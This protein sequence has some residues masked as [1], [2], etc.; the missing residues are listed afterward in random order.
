MADI[1]ENMKEEEQSG[2]FE[3]GSP[4]EE[5]FLLQSKD[6]YPGDLPD[7][8]DPDKPALPKAEDEIAGSAHEE[9]TVEEQSEESDLAG[10]ESSGDFYVAEEIEA[11]GEGGSVWDAFDDL[12]SQPSD[13]KPE[14]T[15]D[16]E[17][18]NSGDEN[19]EIDEETNST[20]LNQ[21]EEVKEEIPESPETEINNEQ[22]QGLSEGIEQAEI[23]EFRFES[24]K[25]DEEEELNSENEQLEGSEDVPVQDGIHL[26]DELKELIKEDLEKKARKK[27]TDVREKEESL[28]KEQDAAEN[29][30]PLDE[31]DAELIDLSELDDEVTP[32][33]EEK[34]DEMKMADNVPAPEIKP[35]DAGIAGVEEKSQKRSPLWLISGIAA[36]LLLISSIVILSYMF[37]FSPDES[38][39]TS[40]DSAKTEKQD[41]MAVKGDELKISGNDKEKDKEKSG[42][43]KGKTEDTTGQVLA[44]I[45]DNNTEKPKK[46]DIADKQ[47]K[48]EGKK[49]VKQPIKTEQIAADKPVEK[50][51]VNQA[52]KQIVE[53]PNNKVEKPVITIKEIEP[54][55]EPAK[56]ESKTKPKPR[57]EEKPVDVAVSTV[58][59]K[60]QETR[61]RVTEFNRTDLIPRDPSDPETG[62]YTIQVY[63]TPSREDAEE[64]L[65]KLKGK[66]IS[67]AFISTYIKRD[68]TWYR[69]RFGKF[70]SREEARITALKHGFAKTWIDRIR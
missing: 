67:G 60:S 44:K 58:P 61:P 59:P 23:D 17:P 26:D 57:S 2:G 15:S 11:P 68:I 14:E 54:K 7:F 33:Q 36:G 64:W 22:V 5:M 56:T 24:L 1:G 4:D 29:F 18:V 40:A 31:E 49:K 53:K 70:T 45:I 46:N 55:K 25:P 39:T 32:A 13:P 19:P 12:E 42:E 10:E 52:T 38:K 69:V 6:E 37:I 8:D 48:S 9:N 41:K 30:E 27:E 47:V 66:N 62:L 35:D 50:K 20:E 16:E 51:S 3:P 43:L 21:I 63:A 34:S 28:E 65:S